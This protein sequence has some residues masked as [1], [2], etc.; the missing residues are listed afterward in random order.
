MKLIV[1]SGSSRSEW[2]ILDEDII[3]RIELP[4]INPIAIPESISTI[5][6]FENPYPKRISEIYY[7]GSGVSNSMAADKIR[8][9]FKISFPNVKISILSDID[10]ACIATSYGESSIVSILGTGVNTVLYNGRQITQSIKSLGYLIEEEGSG[11]NIGKL[12]IKRYLRSMMSSEDS[13]LFR[14]NYLNKGEDLIQLI[15]N[16][17]R[18]NYNIASMST[19]LNECSESLKAEI[20]KENFDIYTLNHIQKIDDYRDYKINFVGSIAY[21]FQ[22]Q[23]IKSIEA[24]GAQVGQIIKNPIS[25]LIKYHINN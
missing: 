5:T 19:F 20:L 3:E 16:H 1:D 24:I 23:L 10:A 7:Y 14:A 25:G 12:V 18:P 15:Y 4:G 13:A 11:F 6:N 17:P 21:V 8:A 2:V 9:A 22:D